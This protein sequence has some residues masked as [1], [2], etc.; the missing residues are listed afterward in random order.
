M[1]LIGASTDVATVADTG[2][3]PVI[4]PGGKGEEGSGN[5]EDLTSLPAVLWG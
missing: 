1:L 2:D 3:L 4:T 5:S